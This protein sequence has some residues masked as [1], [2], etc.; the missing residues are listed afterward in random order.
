LLE[1]LRARRILTALTA[2]NGGLFT[3][4]DADLRESH[5]V[6][7]WR[8]VA[9]IDPR[10]TRQALE[11]LRRVLEAEVAASMALSLSSGAA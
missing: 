8:C 2:D 10:H 3:A 7:P 9:A 11:R 1:R 4:R 5:V 6:V